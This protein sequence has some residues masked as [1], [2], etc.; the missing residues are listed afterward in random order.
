MKQSAN[1]DALL[2]I[3]SEEIP[4]SYIPPALAYMKS[5]CEERL[6]QNLL[7][8][9]TVSIFGTPRRLAVLVTGV[10]PKSETQTDEIIGPSLKVSKDE[11]GEWTQ[12][13]KGFAQS[14][15]VSP[16]SLQARSTARGEYICAVKKHE[17]LKSQEII[18][19]IFADLIPSIPFP[20]KMIWNESQFKFVR[21][22][23]NLVALHGSK[24]LLLTVARVK[25][26]N[27]T[28]PLFHLSPKSI[29]LH[30]PSN[31]L[32]TLKNNCVLAD[33]ES[34]KRA[35]LHSAS[36]AATR[37]KGQLQMDENLLEEIVWL[38]EHPVAILGSFDPDF[39]SLPQEILTTCMKK[40]QKFFSIVDGDGKLMPYFIAIRNG[41]SEHQEIVRSGYE[42]VLR[43][44]LTDAKFFLQEDLKKPLDSHLK[45]SSEIL[46]QGKLGSVG[47]K[48][49][50]M[51]NSA[52]FLVQTLN[53]PEKKERVHASLV[54]RAVH[55]CKFDLVTNMVYEFPELQGIV[56]EIYAV[57]YGEDPRVARAI[58][59]HYYPLS[60]QTEL[61]QSAES[62]VVALVEKI[63]GLVGNF[64]MGLIPTGNTDPY[65][66]KRQ[67]AG[68]LRIVLENRWDISI[69]ELA[70]FTLKQFANQN[71]SE[72]TLSEI[73]SFLTERFQLL[74]RDA[75]Y[76]ID[77]IQSV[78]K[79]LNDVSAKTLRVADLKEKISAIH[80]I[81]THP[82]FDAIAT[83][84][85]R[86]SN[87]LKQAKAKSRS[88]APEL[89]E[90]SLLKEPAEIELHSAM[91]QVYAN[92]Q[93]PLRQKAYREVLQA[94]VQIRVV[95][96]RFFEKVLVMDPDETIC[97]NRLSLLFTLETYLKEV[98]DFS[99]IQNRT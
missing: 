17:G 50:R 81:R 64:L 71:Q 21:P 97:K 22:I 5:F 44:R 34:R 53:A 19:K 3:G 32:A 96:D 15:K 45:K 54:E 76:E 11:K 42:K 49:N 46:L 67:A 20:K 58:R 30:S 24:V 86:A 73:L 6:K 95:L 25:S 36:Q 69:Q 60:N 41:I 48:I 66:L 80:G 40:Q 79:N 51:K 8:Y 10:P 33:P 39:L 92:I 93:S 94:W 31:Y 12:A 74:M 27:K 77:E 84:F 23:R 9:Q 63:E 18:K 55:L 16:D 68:I 1:Q 35:I 14:Q 75:G 87:I 61:P 72:R 37:L 26:S 7:S 52:Q 62:G 2:E 65:G 28:F 29:A 38:V 98:A 85:K 78:T 70:E 13:A 89:L 99:L 59:E 43:A 83:A 4:A 90:Q 47:D 57:R 56:G 82:D 91:M 88:Y